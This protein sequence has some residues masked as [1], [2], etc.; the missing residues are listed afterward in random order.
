MSA[1]DNENVRLIQVA[2]EQAQAGQTCITIAHRLPTIQNSDKI[3]V[4]AAKK[5]REMG[6]H[7]QLIEQHGIYFNLWKAQ[8]R[9]DNN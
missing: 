8:Q 9:S 5:I 1:L 6:R 2:L 4:V 7:E 3:C